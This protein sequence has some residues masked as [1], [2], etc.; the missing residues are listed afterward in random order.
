MINIYSAKNKSLGR[1]CSEI[2]KYMLENLEHKTCI[3]Y[4]K[5]IV[6]KKTK[7][8]YKHTGY[9]GGLKKITNVFLIKK[10]GIEFLIKKTLFGMLPKTRIYRN[11]LNKIIFI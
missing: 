10:F 11:L 6:Y 4:I 8:F 3:K 2:S 1:L 7:F 9:P 5:D